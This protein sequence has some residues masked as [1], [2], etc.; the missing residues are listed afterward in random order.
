MPLKI[1]HIDNE[2]TGCGACVSSCSQDALK[3]IY[4]KEGFYYPSL[5]SSRC[6]DCKLCEKSCHILNPIPHEAPVD[7]LAYMG[8]SKSE[9]IRANSSSGGAFTLLANNIINKGGVV[10][11]ARYNYEKERLEQT[12]TDHVALSELQ[13]SKY[14]ESYVGDSF[15][16][17]RK[18]LKND[19]YVMYCG[20]P[21]QISGLK[22][23]L[24]KTKQTKLLL[25]DFICHGVPSNKN[26]T[27]YK[28]FL[29]KKEK[30]K[31]VHLDFRPKTKG[32][33]TSNIL[34]EFKN[35]KIKD[36]VYPLSYYYSHFQH[37][38]FLRKSCYTCN[39]PKR[40]LSDITIAD[41]WGIY[42]YK[43]SVDD[44]KGLSLIIINNQKGGSYLKEINES[45]EVEELPHSAVQY[46]Y[47]RN[48]EAYSIAKRMLM[49]EQINKN[50]FIPI[51]RHLYLK[52]I[53]LRRVRIFGGNILRFIR[54]KK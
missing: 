2:C 1:L 37:N 14:I 32:W 50:G 39:Y 12:D 24:G 3:L 53:I 11:G 41:F 23:Y 48:P 45:C 9:K 5:D 28:N 4:D 18:Y 25:V 36:I 54:I 52:K 35:N 47:K 49:S 19:R 13:K 16:I 51:M 46:V 27:A 31:I 43:P 15:K 8:K 20:T 17:I 10:F 22:T 34:L 29:E 26:F 21:C 33:H 40:H 30:S 7:Y 44:N 42:K 38:D 6:I